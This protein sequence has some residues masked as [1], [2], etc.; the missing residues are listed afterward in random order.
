MSMFTESV[1]TLHNFSKHKEPFDYCNPCQIVIRQHEMALR[2]VT[3]SVTKKVAGAA[4]LLL[5]G[6]RTK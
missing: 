1:Q 2:T 6:D 5:G 3:K 4:A